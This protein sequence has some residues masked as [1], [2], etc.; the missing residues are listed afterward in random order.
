M[1]SS[2]ES[3][4]KEI[5]NAEQVVEADLSVDQLVDLA[6]D[7]P[8]IRL[9]NSVIAGGVTGNASDIHIEPQEKSVRVRYRMDGILYEQMTIPPNH[10]PA[11][12]S[13]IKIMSHLN[14]AERRRPQDG[15]IVFATDE[16]DYDLRVS[17]MP[18]IYGEKVVM[19]VLDKSGISVPLERLG[20]FQEQRHLFES[21]ITRPHGM[22]L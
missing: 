13:R 2:A 4:L 6:E 21:F 14:I 12:V 19:R 9:V 5:E 7:A 22:I 1:R 8:I 10:H 16:L 18:T 15:R 17:T 20:F 3:V 11:V